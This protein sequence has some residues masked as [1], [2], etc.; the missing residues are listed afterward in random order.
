MP[1]QAGA[2]GF[3]GGIGDGQKDPLDPRSVIVMPLCL[4]RA[5]RQRNSV[6]SDPL[7]HCSLMSPGE[8]RVEARSTKLLFSI[9]YH[10]ASADA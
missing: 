1:S 4:G 7:Q 8:E 3:A 2:A 10:Y 6:L 5:P 9:L